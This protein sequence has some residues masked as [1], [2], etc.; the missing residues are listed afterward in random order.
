MV[1]GLVP[2]EFHKGDAQD[3]KVVIPLIALQKVC[4]C[5]QYNCDIV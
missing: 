5:I 1:V 2:S 3:I 4:V